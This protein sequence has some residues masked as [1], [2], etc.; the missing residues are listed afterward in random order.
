MKVLVVGP[1]AYFSTWDVYEGHLAGFRA[2]GCEVFAFDYGKWLRTF[3]EFAKWMKRYRK[4]SP[5]LTEKIYIMGSESIYVTARVHEVDLVWMVAPMHV[6]PAILGLMLRDGIKTAGYM[7][8]CPYEDDQWINRAPLLTY[9]FV[10]D[11][12]SVSRF[13]QENPRSFYMG[14]SYDPKRHISQ[15]RGVED[16]DVTFVGT[17]FPARR[18]FLE[19]VNWEGIDVRLWGYWKGVP[20]RS[21]IDPYLTRCILD[22]TET[23]A[24]Y[25]RSRIG[26]QLHRKD[27]WYGFK[28][29]C[30]EPAYS[31]GPRSYELA[32]CGVF[33]V[34]D[35]RPELHEVF[36]GSIPTF[37]TPAELEGL[38][39][40][41]LANP[42]E[43]QKLA[44]KQRQAVQPYTFENRIKQALELIA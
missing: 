32:A 25:K 30:E 33:Q 14:H 7:T 13:Q 34:S 18:K 24:L 10:N 43:R 1:A 39:R 28:G 2:N 15:K 19:A 42:G 23:T 36:D 44:E 40:R 22:N 17:G 11:K 37:S 26:L 38:I 29:E 6:H 16:T 9:C 12:N 27:K 21:A 4:G 3:G 35:E 31:L 5:D 20:K 8:E 41:Y